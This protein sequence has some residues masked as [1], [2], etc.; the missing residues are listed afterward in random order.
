MIV[1]GFFAANIMYWRDKRNNKRGIFDKRGE[2]FPVS[3]AGIYRICVVFCGTG[4]VAALSETLPGC[5]ERVG[6][7]CAPV[8]FVPEPWSWLYFAAGPCG[9]TLRIR[10][11]LFH[12]LHEAAPS[13]TTVVPVL[14]AGGETGCEVLPFILW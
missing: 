2:S 10:S 6:W 7:M 12:R 9:A 11:V 4:A 14:T 8:S 3:Y 1:S 5:V 13:G